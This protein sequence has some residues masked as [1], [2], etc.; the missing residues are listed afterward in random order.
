MGGTWRTRGSCE[1]CRLEE[2]CSVA[3]LDLDRQIGVRD[4]LGTAAMLL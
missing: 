3:F 4:F 2:V 1:D